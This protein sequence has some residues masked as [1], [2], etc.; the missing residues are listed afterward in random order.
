[1]SDERPS[2][3]THARYLADPEPE[4]QPRP[5]SI[6]L[7]SIVSLILGTAITLASSPTISSVLS[8]SLDAIY[9]PRLTSTSALNTFS[10]FVTSQALL[11]DLTFSFLISFLILCNYDCTS[12]WIA[13][14][15]S[16]PYSYSPSWNFGPRSLDFQLLIF[17]TFHVGWASRTIHMLNIVAEE[18]LWTTVILMTFGKTG[19]LAFSTA[20]IFQAI[21]YGDIWVGLGVVVGNA[22]SFGTCWWLVQHVV[23]GTWAV[24][25]TFALSL[26]KTALFWTVTV[27]TLS[28]VLEPLPPTYRP[29]VACF[30]DNFGA[31]GWKLCLSDLPAALWLVILGNVS[32]FG[33][34]MPGRLFN[35]VVYK[36]MYKAGFRSQSGLLDVRDAKLQAWALIRGGWTAHPETAKMYEWAC[37]EIQCLPQEKIGEK[38]T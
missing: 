36:C 15:R 13:R 5:R 33:A 34:G 17:E 26:V 21:T 3:A 25:E 12:R 20:L 38:F 7:P 30:D 22:A 18:G 6:V 27:R 16:F 9:A 10:V 2:E 1:M 19:A 4:T 32:E 8:W 11:T 28:H 31:A 29:D 24:D 35:I 14:N 23:M 37:S